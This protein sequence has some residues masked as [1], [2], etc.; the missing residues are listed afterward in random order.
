MLKWIE[1]DPADDAENVILAGLLRV[2]VGMRRVEM[3]FELATANLGTAEGTC[4]VSARVHPP[5]GALVAGRHVQEEARNRFWLVLFH[6]SAL[7]GVRSP[8]AAHPQRA[9][10]SQAA[11]GRDSGTRR[12]R[13][14]LQAFVRGTCPR[15]CTT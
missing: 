9:A 8:I 1:P 14:A 2:V 10:N 7:S 11:D 15:K 6:L 3:L 4:N 12:A 13:R 5:E